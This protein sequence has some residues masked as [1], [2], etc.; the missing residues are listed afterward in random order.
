MKF[1]RIVGFSMTASFVCLLHA[2]AEPYFP[3]A[4]GTWKTVLAKEAGF[5]AKKIEKVLDYAEEMMSSSVVVLYQGRIVA[6]RH[7]HPEK[8]S[9]SATPRYR[10]MVVDT[11]KD[12]H[13]V[14]DVASVQKSV[15][16]FLAGVAIGKGRLEL[17][18]PASKY[19]GE[20]WCN[21]T[22]EQETAITVRHL[23][24]MSSGLND[25]LEYQVSAG[26]MWRYN[27]GAYS[28]TIPV[29][30][31]AL[32]MSIDDLTRKYITG[33]IGMADSSWE[34]RPWAIRNDAANKIGFATSARDLAR[35]GILMLAD[36]TWDGK[37]ILQSPGY[38]KESI[39]SSQDMNPA[40]GLLWWLNGKA[41]Y[42]RAANPSRTAGSMVP[43][44]PDDMVS[45]NGALSRHLF[46]VPSMDLVVTRLGNNPGRGFVPEFWRLLMAA[47]N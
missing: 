29:L 2:T 24:S 22:R 43:T 8:D 23:M 47:R 20:G 40:Y 10:R 44:A 32:G 41:S 1:V 31:K 30:E 35:I 36:G 46:I 39:S 11:T 42:L 45:A 19:L 9:A 33:P 6:E 37:D 28:K 34:P 26:T 16:S 13:N 25:A 12:G 5:D 17:E 14:E 4:T 15:I 27:T 21:A 38:L 7:V 3:P 18:D